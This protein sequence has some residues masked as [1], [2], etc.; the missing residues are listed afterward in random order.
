MTTSL[1]EQYWRNQGTLTAL[2]ADASARRYFRLQTDEKTYIIADCGL[3]PSLLKQCRDQYEAFHSQSL[4]IPLVD[5]W[6]EE[7]HSYRL[8]DLGSKHLISCPNYMPQAFGLIEQLQNATA[9][10]YVRAYN[11]SYEIRT[12]FENYYLANQTAQLQARY[13]EHAEQVWDWLFKA[14]ELIPIRWSHGDF[15]AENIMIYDEK[16]YMIDYQDSS[17]APFTLDYVSL[18]DDVRVPWNIELRE[19]R[20]TY[21]THK[22][23]CNFELSPETI[24]HSLE[25]TSALRLLR[26]LG[27]FTRLSVRDHKHHYLGYIPQIRN[28]IIHLAQD[29]PKMLPLLDWI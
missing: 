7:S 27:V 6:H 19:Q 26:I 12:L 21:Y 20:M 24:H 18:I 13:S 29:M 8:Q 11:K 5:L 4:P 28:M 10:S 16:L 22:L 2:K 23:A 15:H 9:P 3:E 25:V 17:L 1:A 14:Y